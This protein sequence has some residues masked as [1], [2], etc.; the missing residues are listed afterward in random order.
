M[1]RKKERQHVLDEYWARP[2]PN[3]VDVTDRGNSLEVSS[4]SQEAAA[5]WLGTLRAVYPQDSYRY[6]Y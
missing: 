6:L 4:C 5:W 1:S 3:E 2:S